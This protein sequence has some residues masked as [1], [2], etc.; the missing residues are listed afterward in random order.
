MPERRPIVAPR[1][2]AARRVGGP[3]VSLPIRCACPR[4]GVTLTQ[5]TTLPFR[6]PDAPLLWTAPNVYDAPRPIEMDLSGASG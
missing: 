4:A 1:Q 6:F 3:R 5:M 2:R